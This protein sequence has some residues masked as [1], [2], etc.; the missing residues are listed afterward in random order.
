M[1]SDVVKLL[2]E[3]K[4]CEKGQNNNSCSYT[5]HYYSLDLTLFHST[6]AWRSWLFPLHTR[7][8]NAPWEWVCLMC[9]CVFETCQT[10]QEVM[11]SSSRLWDWE[12]LQTAF[13]KESQSMQITFDEGTSNMLSNEKQ[14]YRLNCC[15]SSSI[16]YNGLSVLHVKWI[17]LTYPI[18]S[19]FLAGIPKMFGFWL[20]SYCF[21]TCWRLWQKKWFDKQCA[22]IVHN[23]PIMLCEKAGPTEKSKQCKYT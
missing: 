18:N 2:V 4:K 15:T 17:Q 21:H 6:Q 19:F 9:A 1:C 13:Y 5:A 3:N 11:C 8:F 22:N 23:Q 12:S 10:E 7:T 14:L 16:Q 20:F